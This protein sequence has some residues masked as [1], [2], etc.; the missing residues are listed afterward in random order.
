MNLCLFPQLTLGLRKNDFDIYLGYKSFFGL[1]QFE[2]GSIRTG[3]I[4][5]TKNNMFFGIEGGVNHHNIANNHRFVGEGAIF[6]GFILN[7][8]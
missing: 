6:A 4:W 5:N 8:K 2:I 3:L 7:R 1:D